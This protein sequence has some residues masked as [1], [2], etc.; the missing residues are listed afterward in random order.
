MMTQKCLME[1]LALGSERITAWADILDRINVFPVPD[2]DTGRN[3]V[4]S[5]A[6]FNQKTSPAP[7]LIKAL[8][9]N[10]RGNSG[11][12]MASFMSGFLSINDMTDLSIPCRKGRDL[13]Y[14]AVSDP[15]PGTI[16]EFFDVL[17]AS[18]E[19]NPR[20]PEGLWLDRV[21]LDLE[22]VVKRTATGLAEIKRAGVVDAGALG[23][24]VFFDSTLKY[25][26]G[27]DS[28]S[29][30][31]G[32]KFKE[33]LSP[34]ASSE[35]QV[36]GFCVDAILEKK[37]LKSISAELSSLGKSI[38]M[39]ESG[40]Y[41]KLH[42]HTGNT[43]ETK[44]R[45]EELGNVIAWAEDDMGEQA[46][47]FSRVRRKQAIHIMT[48]AAGSMTRNDARELNVTLLDSY[49]TVGDLCLPETYHDP[50]SMLEAMRQ[51]V[52][53]STSRASTIEQHQ[54]YQKVL[55]LYPR[56][57][58]LCV[59]SV[60]TGNYEVVKEWKKRNDS[61]E[62]L[63][64]I[65]TGSASGKL[66]LAARAVAEFS[67]EADDPDQV[68]RYAVKAVEQCREYIF[69][70]TLQY[71]AAGGRMSKTGAFF[72]DLLHV[73]PIVS[74]TPEGAAKAGI[75]RSAKDQLTF[76]YKRLAQF[77]AGNHDAIIMLEYTDNI[78]WVK[79]QVE[80]PIRKRY[81][82][83]RVILQQISLTSSVHMGPGTWGIA[84]LPEKPNP[85]KEADLPCG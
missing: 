35:A 77:M 83:T 76:A 14:Q 23:M 36:E 82:R 7:D 63:A 79:E 56:V 13:A 49:I 84:F 67:L 24:F 70:D 28:T 85:P 3:L 48:D 15:K 10:A 38:V 45:L 80:G 75:A 1:A 62:R 73:K 81:P 61:E 66:G 59:G 42:F 20:D 41:L 33:F 4:V 47:R 52:K 44:K 60:Y 39:I 58:Y 54:Y 51:G 11:N 43:L 78:N 21:M 64:V 32:E 5:L 18:L 65:D 16:L 26:A 12:I 74:P 30:G 40:N 34:A 25:L 29:N 22:D 53:A 19:E 6:P 72:G 55:S 17:V 27:L 37:K 46:R 9:I 57:L 8:L 69:L 68:V 50:L 71:L 31:L 2:G